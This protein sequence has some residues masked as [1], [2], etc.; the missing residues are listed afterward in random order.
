MN[1][2][3]I[4]YVSLS[5]STQK[6]AE[7]MC[8]EFSAQGQPV[9]LRPISEISDLSA[10]DHIIAGGLLYRF[11]W[12]PEIIRFLKMNRSELREKKVALFVTGL[13]LVKTPYCDNAPFPIFIDPSMLNNS[14]NQGRK[15]LLDSFTTINGYL[16]R[17]LPTIEEIKPVSLG[18][19]AG[20]LELY[21]LK[22]LEQFMLILLMLLANMKPGDHRNWESIRA[23]VKSLASFNT[24]VSGG[25]YES[26]HHLR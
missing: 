13:R 4:T 17:A 1:R 22:P 5:G 6:I 26:A 19:F 25:E 7:F 3:L 10:Y 20:K 2:L 15:Y 11:G 16:H 23:W 8:T 12:H 9:D 14:T 24:E 21:T 18:F